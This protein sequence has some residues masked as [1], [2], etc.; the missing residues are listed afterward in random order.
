MACPDGWSTENKPNG[1]F[2]V[3]LSIVSYQAFTL[4][5]L[6]SFPFFNMI[7]S[8]AFLNPRLEVLCIYMMVSDF[9]FYG[10]S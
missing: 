8:F 4:F 1:I 5:V 6:F 3:S 7:S 10:I 2:G 9:I